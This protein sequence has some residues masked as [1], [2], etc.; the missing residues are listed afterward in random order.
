MD[1]NFGKSER[2][3]IAPLIRRAFK[4]MLILNSDYDL[5]RAQAELKSGNSDAITFGRPF[6]ANPDLPRRFAE[7]IPLAQDDRETWFTQ[8]PEGYLNYAE[9]AR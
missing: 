6:I 1:G 5:V 2:P 4:G 9:A 8:G 3:P 7:G